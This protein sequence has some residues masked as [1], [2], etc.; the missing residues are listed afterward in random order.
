MDAASSA[1]AETSADK[2]ILGAGR[3]KAKPS[4]DSH[5]SG[6]DQ[7]SEPLDPTQTIAPA[8][9]GLPGQPAAAR[10]FDTTHR[11]SRLVQH[12]VRALAR[13]QTLDQMQLRPRWPPGAASSA[14]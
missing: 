11:H 1:L 12:F 5:G 14:G 9:V 4:D 13:V 10:S 3:A 2:D 6:G 7:Q 8:N